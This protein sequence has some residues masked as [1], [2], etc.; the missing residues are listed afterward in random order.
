MQKLVSV[1][2][3]FGN[4]DIKRGKQ[5]L[6]DISSRMTHA[7]TKHPAEE[8]DNMTYMEA[9]QAARAENY[10]VYHAIQHETVERAKD[11]CLDEIVVCIRILNGECKGNKK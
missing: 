5:V 8:W 2:K 3:A 7:K 6:F 1:Y 10:E 11:E 4:G 9:N